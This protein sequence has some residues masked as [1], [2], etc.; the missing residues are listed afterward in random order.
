MT[1]ITIITFTAGRRPKLLRRCIESVNSAKSD[2]DRHLIIET[3]EYIQSKKEIMNIPGF[4]TFVDD[5][6][7]IDRDAINVSRLALEKFNVGACFTYEKVQADPLSDFVFND[8]TNNGAKSYSEICLSPSGIHHLVVFNSKYCHADCFKL[9][10]KFSC[11]IDW[12][13]KASAALQGG[14]VK[15]PTIGY[16]WNQHS[17]QETK[18]NFQTKMSIAQPDINLFLESISK[19]KLTQKIEEYKKE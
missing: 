4:I 15:V 13:L 12:L 3:Q 14:C 6:D 19:F 9:Q 10:D 8:Y 7:Y 18:S 16:Y 2:I 17:V 11:G 5:D 1:P